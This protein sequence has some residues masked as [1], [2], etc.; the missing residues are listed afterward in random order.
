MKASS[1]NRL[2]NLIKN[3]LDALEGNGGSIS[4]VTDFLNEKQIYVDVRD[5]G[6]GVTAREKKNI[7]NPGYS[8]KKRGW[9]LGL[10]LAKRIIEDYHDGY[11][12]LKETQPNVGS[13]FR[14]ILNIKSN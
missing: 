10:S 7:F 1:C 4:I 2:E 8:T 3:A 5:S 6:K 13:T 12:S 9:G 14:I 11:L